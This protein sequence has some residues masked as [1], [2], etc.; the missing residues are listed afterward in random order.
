MPDSYWLA[1]FLFQRGLGLVYFIAFLAVIRQFRPLVGEDGLLPF[2]DFVEHV[3]FRESPSLLYFLPSDRAARAMAWTGLT[4]SAFALT[5]LS[6]M[7]GTVFSM[8]TW[9]LLWLIYLSFVNVGQTFYSFGWESMLLEAGFLAIFL[10]GMNTAAPFLV[11]LMLRWMLFRVEFGAGLIKLR[12]DS[13][14]RELTCLD[15]HHETQPMP[16]PLSRFAH[17]LPEKFHR[18]ETA[19]NHLVQ[20]A[21][22]FLY[23]APQPFAAVAGALTIFSQSWLILTGNYAFLNLLTIVLAVSTFGDQILTGLLESIGGIFM[24]GTSPAFTTPAVEPVSAPHMLGIYLLAGAVVL[25]SYWPVK[26]MLSPRQ[27]MN[28]GFNPLHLV[29]TYGAFGSVTRTRYEVVIEG[30]TDEDLEKAD[31]HEYEFYGKPTKLDSRPPQIAPYHLRLDWQMWFA[32]MSP[33]PR[34]PWFRRF[35]DR[36]ARDD[37][38]VLKLLKRKP[39]DASPA[40]VRARRY[41]YQFTSPEER[42]Q[43]GNHWKRTLV[44]DYY[45]A[46]RGDFEDGN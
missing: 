9:L 7:F 31:W 1:A 14:W 41:R 12:A 21:V 45:P 30:T 25:L 38:E 40:Y 17:H 10:G 18:L 37:E 5:G 32:A 34:R 8:A 42:K 33:R 29:N 36:L 16:N 6:E 35:M 11:I 43:T 27:K 19:S 46:L 28:A 4:L 20:L 24:P 23:F 13:C 2:T 39:F 26:N 22:P 3:D 15:Y 44:N